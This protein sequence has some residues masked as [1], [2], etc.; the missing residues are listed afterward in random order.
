MNP[1]ENLDFESGVVTYIDTDFS[2]E[3]L[4]EDMLQVVYPKDY[5]LDVGWYGKSN[6]FLIYI[7][8]NYD[9]DNPIL[10]TQTDIFNLRKTVVCAVKMIESL[11]STKEQK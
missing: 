2:P 1:F 6:E 10:S 11:I 8:R 9:W 7:I 5:M 4:R 3:N